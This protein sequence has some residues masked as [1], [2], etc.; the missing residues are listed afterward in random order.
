MVLAALLL[1]SSAAGLAGAPP[2]ALAPPSAQGAYPPPPPNVAPNLP[3]P[4]PPPP[5]AGARLLFGVGLELGLIRDVSASP[6]AHSSFFA[7]ETIETDLGAGLYLRIGAQFDDRW[8]A[9]AELSGATEISSGDLRAAL[10]A[11]VSPSDWL[12][13]AF[14]PTARVDAQLGQRGPPT[15][16]SVG[17]TVR[18]DL[19][20]SPTRRAGVRSAWTIG[21]AVDGGLTVAGTNFSGS[22]PAFGFYLTLGWAR[23]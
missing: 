21:L 6:V 19:H 8:G 17:S 18:F 11:D 12:T 9:E 13:L 1:V 22:G 16:E 15:T 7:L 3:P 4:P 20:L 5:D 14:G 23:Y 2:A 10:T